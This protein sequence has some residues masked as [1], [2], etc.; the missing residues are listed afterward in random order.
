MQDRSSSESPH[1]TTRKHSRSQR[2]LLWIAAA[3]FIV[4]VGV[5]IAASILL[6]RAE[7][8][9]RA[10]VI[11]TLS[12]RF[13][14]RVE[15]GYFHVYV[16]N[17]LEVT[18]GD[19][20]LY[21]NDLD[22]QAPLFAV[23][24]F[25][26][27][28]GWRSFLHTPM[29][30]GRVNL[31]GLALTM[32]PKEDRKNMPKMKNGEG[33]GK[34]QIYV[35]QLLVKDAKLVLETNKPGKTPLEWD[36]SNLALT[37]IGAGQ[38]LAFHAILTNPK[39][40]GNIDSTGHFGPFNTESPGDTPIDGAY[41]FSHAD[42]NSLKG[43]GGMLSSQGKYVGTLNNMVVDGETDTPDFQVDTGTHPIPLHTK[44]H[45]IVDG[46]NG[47]T[48]LQPVD[49]QLGHSHIVAT[50]K[51][52][53]VR[54]QGHQITLDVVVGPA[55]IEDM[56]RLGVKTMPPIMQ[57][58]LKLKTK[59]DIP[60][61]KVSVT[62]KMR[63]KGNFQVLDAT[64]SND[65]VQAKVDELSLRSQGKA[66]EAKKIDAQNPA[67]I[68]SDMQGVFELGD[69]KLTFSALNYKLPGADIN[70]T[71]VY[72]LDGNEFDFHGMARLDAKVSQMMTGWKSILLKPVDPFFSKHGAGTEVPIKI[73]GTRS[74]P[75]FGLDFKHKDDKDSPG[76]SPN[77]TKDSNSAGKSSATKTP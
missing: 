69:S 61:G 58:S 50:G 59:L 23:R 3:F 20:H 46:T 42:L 24:K 41:N 1:G 31:E 22:M 32:P 52:V 67:L 6:R 73:T 51:V 29:H 71:G 62:Q 33:G 55:R 8:V 18:G 37:S 54:G 26:F 35:D 11:E 17:G 25:S 10:R 36:V 13:D 56:L 21:P 45:A 77:K 53:L 48:Y 76:G 49:A 5:F 43:I 72:S 64:F 60:P 4:V 34:I 66:G 27:K 40:V 9:L 12:A 63:L 14:S 44:F 47:D 16:L 7:P 38:P 28:T 57:G 19:L 75:K 30:V 39:P 68:Q 65:K 74:E 2:I 15:L 70:L